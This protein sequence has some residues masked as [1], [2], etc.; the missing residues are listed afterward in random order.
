MRRAGSRAGVLQGG[1]EREFSGVLEVSGSRSGASW[2][3][4][5]L[6]FTA[7]AGGQRFSS[8]PLAE[9]VALPSDVFSEWA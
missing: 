9:N 4:V 6:R 7:V 3:N 5:A 1:F 2:G 8:F